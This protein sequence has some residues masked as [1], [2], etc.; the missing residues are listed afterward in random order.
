MSLSRQIS[1]R[2]VMLSENVLMSCKVFQEADVAK[3]VAREERLFSGIKHQ[4]KLFRQATAA[5]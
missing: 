5:I 2:M 3:A 1:L 4:I